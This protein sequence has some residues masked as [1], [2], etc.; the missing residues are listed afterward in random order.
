MSNPFVHIYRYFSRHRLFF[1]LFNLVL[2]FLILFLASRIRLEE[3]ITG[4]VRN[5]D[6]SDLFNLVT[7]RFRFTDK[8]I[9]HLF[10]ADSASPADPSTLTGFAREITDSIAACFDSG[11]VRSV[12]GN[13]SDTGML[14]YMAFL[15]GNLPVFLEEEDYTAIDSMI[16]PGAVGGSLERNYKALLTPAG[17]LLK[18]RIREDPLGLGNLVLKKLK[19]L[20]VSGQFT[21]A[22]GFIA[23]RDRKNI[24]IFV[25]PANPVN[26]TSKNSQLVKG[27]DRILE[28]TAEKYKGSVKGRYFGAIAMAAGN[29]AQLKQDI[30]LTILI[31]LVLIVLLIGWY[32]RSIK[33]PLLGFLPALYGGGLSL[34][35]LFLVKGT[36]SA[37]ALGIGSVILGLIVDYALYLIN[38]Y[39][40]HGDMEKVIRQMSGTI[41]ICAVTS[42]GAF[43]CLVFL[44]SSVLHDLGWFA[45][46][47]VLGAAL[48]ALVILPQFLGKGDTRKEATRK[49]NFIDR[50][51]SYPF[52]KKYGFI[53]FFLL[54]GIIS[55]FFLHKV[56]FQK[57]MT[58]MNFVPDKLSRAEKDLDRIAGVSLKNIYLVSTGKDLEEALKIQER[59]SGKVTSLLQAGIVTGISGPGILLASDSLQSQRIR[60]WEAFW[61]PERT[62]RLKK[63]LEEQGSRFRFREGSFSSFFRMLEKKYEPVPPDSLFRAGEQ[64]IADWVSPDSGLVSVTTVLKVREEQRQ[65]V[66]QSISGIPGLVVF[67]RQ[68]LTEQFVASVRHDFNRLVIFSM[69]FVTLLLFLALGRIEL[70]VVTALPMYLSWLITLGFMGM[71][72]IR[73]TIFNIIISSFVFGLGVDYSILMMRGLIMDYKYGTKDI[74]SCKASV[75][76]SSVTTLFGVGALFFARHP[77]LNSIALISVVGIVAVV[78]I[79]YIF[80]PLIAEWLFFARTR[81][82]KF[83]LTA[84]I[85]VKSFVTWGN[86]VLVAI[87]Q[88]IAAFLIRMLFFLSREKKEYLFHKLFQLLCGAYIWVTFPRDRK[89]LDP[90]G[91]DFSKPAIIISNHQSLIET[92]AFLRLS[93]KILILTRDWVWKSPLFGPI[94]R[95]AG[96]PNVDEGMDVLTDRLREKI[97]RG[98]SILIFPEAHRSP[99]QHVQRFHRGA[100]YLA[101]KLRLDILPLVVFGTGD[102]LAKHDFWGK[103]NGIRMKVLGRVGPENPHFGGNYSTRTRQFRKFIRDEF[104][105]LRSDDGTGH[106]YRRL[107]GLNYIYKGPVLEWYL[108]VKMKLAGNYEI[109]NSLVPREGSVLD[110]GC[111]YGLISF[112]LALTGPGRM[113]HGLDYDPEKIAVASNGFLKRDNLSFT[114]TDVMDYPMAQYT[115]FLLSDVLHYLPGDRQE[116]LL[117]RCLDNLEPEGIILIRDADRI[118]GRKHLRTRFSEFFSTRFGFNKTA[119]EDKHLYFTSVE[120][121]RKIA[122]K[123]GMRLDIIERSRR[124][125]NVLMA[126]RK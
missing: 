30:I 117:N 107:L 50:L 34:A 63:D 118:K 14:P 112:M 108:K 87:L 25:T 88:I 47:S 71:T 31:A 41:L 44:R 93:P 106:Y 79:S 65:P 126:I 100:F 45:A 8:L 125:S 52:E 36:V 1:Y 3:E 6:N 73:F 59:T 38:Q 74:A 104:H 57:D 97:A 81:Q 76:I 49:P 2:L 17:F 22:D 12:L 124:T 53:G 24:L 90:H 40:R 110:I 18:N 120:T 113:I 54:A 4:V 29:A 103:P 23:T 64:F 111:G 98:F 46:I 15:S 20:Q 119:D 35:V 84:R 115:A 102:F 19:S 75:F 37:I 122:E 9:I 83:P 70:E 85:V 48:F 11:Y 21:I 55:L 78:M 92:P 109:Y 95:L 67:D 62:E 80:Q 42:A 82:G 60:R 69:V 123:R 26:E 116:E 58:A 94:A 32:F 72:G 91:E 5:R 7:T 56:E 61:T 99:D 66:Y 89:Y 105:R 10:P 77:A 96:F 51:A 114:C 43:L 101:E 121:I 86:I 68:V 16:A 39:H 27:I 13:I 33:I 28:R